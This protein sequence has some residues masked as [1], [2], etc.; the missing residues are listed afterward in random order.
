MIIQAKMSHFGF[1]SAPLNFPPGQLPAGLHAPGTIIS[2]NP[3]A[4]GSGATSAYAA[5]PKGLQGSAPELPG[6]KLTPAECAQ[7]GVPVGAVWGRPEGAEA[8]YPSEEV[9]E[10]DVR[11]TQV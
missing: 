8:P 9:Q 4:A 3:G 7:F 2:G 11:G 5:L 1:P 10:D 6:Q